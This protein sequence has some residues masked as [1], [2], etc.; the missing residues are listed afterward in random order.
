M[1][2]E[3]RFKMLT[4]IKPDDAKRFFDK[5]QHDAETRWQ[6]YSYLAARRPAGAATVPVTNPTA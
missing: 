1:M 4:K 5:A 3:N 2:S 6:L